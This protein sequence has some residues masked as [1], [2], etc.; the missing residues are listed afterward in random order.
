M[1]YLIMRALINAI[2]DYK[3]I[4]KI[5][6]ILSFP[7]ALGILLLHFIAKPT[8]LA[9]GGVFLRTSDLL[10]MNFLILLSVF[11]GVIFSLSLISI[12]VTSISLYVKE[13]R[14]T[15]KHWRKKMMKKITRDILPITFFFLFLFI[16]NFILQSTSLIISHLVI[17]NLISLFIY[18]ITLFVP[19]AIAI[20]NYSIDTALSKSYKLTMKK[21]LRPILWLISVFILVSLLHVMSIYF[22]GYSIGSWISYI[23]SSFIVLPFSLVLGSHLYMDKY[24]LS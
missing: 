5:I 21:P 4:W 7:A 1:Q 14:T 8:Y 15:D 11:I 10:R 9:I 16:F 12:S 19:F 17:I 6:T 24:P 23:L 2:S 22:I 3:K 13:K 18:L 20:D